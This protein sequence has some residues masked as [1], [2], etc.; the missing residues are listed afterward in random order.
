MTIS[1]HRRVEMEKQIALLTVILMLNAGYTVLVDNGGE[2]NEHERIV[3]AEGASE[4]LCASDHDHLIAVNPVGHR[5]GWA[6]LVYGNN[7]HDTLSDY[8]TNLEPLL[9]VV[10]ELSDKFEEECDAAT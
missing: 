4:M 6:L 9:T 8:T 5:V 3:R 10:H 7:G 1:N 2:D